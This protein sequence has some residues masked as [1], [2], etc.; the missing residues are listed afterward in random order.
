MQVALNCQSEASSRLW[1]GI[2][3]SD[4]NVE[5]LQ[6][7][8]VRMMS[9]AEN[10]HFSIPKIIENLHQTRF[11]VQITAVRQHTPKIGTFYLAI[12]KTQ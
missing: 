10:I 5:I 4:Q 3:I 6:T 8:S 7:S 12:R 11:F 9:G 2:E 1:K